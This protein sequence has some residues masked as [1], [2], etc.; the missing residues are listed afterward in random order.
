[1]ECQ[2]CCPR[3]DPPPEAE[4]GDLG[5]VNHG[6]A[7]H[8]DAVHEVRRVAGPVAEGERRQPDEAEQ[9]DAEDEEECTL[10]ASGPPIG[11]ARRRWRKRKTPTAMSVMS[12][13]TGTA[14]L[15][16][17]NTERPNTP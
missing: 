10:H 1:M 6:C 12:W 13:T 8:P 16:N 7:E 15:K 5:E 17:H 4:H 11:S 14:A 3:H 2:E 9:R